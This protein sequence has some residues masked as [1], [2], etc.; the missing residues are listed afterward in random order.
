MRWNG[1]RMVGVR[2]GR[3]NLSEHRGEMAESEGWSDDNK[4]RPFS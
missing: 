1:I 4:G 2:L 3:P